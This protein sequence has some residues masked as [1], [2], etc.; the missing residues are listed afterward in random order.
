MTQIVIKH[1]KIHIIK[2]PPNETH[3]SYGNNCRH[4]IDCPV[5]GFHLSDFADTQSDHQRKKQPRWN[6]ENYK[7]D[8]SPH[9]IPKQRVLKCFHIVAKSPEFW[10]GC[11]DQLI[12]EQT[13]YESINDRN[14]HK[15]R[16]KKQVWKKES[17]V[18][19]SFQRKTIPGCLVENPFTHFLSFTL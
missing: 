3:H 15:Y 13:H 9:P 6:S 7:T 5:K 18:K 19:P 10:R 12:S 4:K 16:E 2:P 8:S 1:S 17:V 11:R 14:Q